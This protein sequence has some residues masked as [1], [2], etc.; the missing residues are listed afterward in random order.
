MRWTAVDSDKSRH[1]DVI[2]TYFHL[3]FIL[4]NII[5]QN[6]PQIHPKCIANNVFGSITL[7]YGQNLYIDRY[8][9][10]NKTKQAVLSN[11]VTLKINTQY[12]MPRAFTS[13]GDVVF[14]DQ[15]R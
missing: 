5:G 7:L 9:W 14:G 10:S 11:G 12:S 1:L 2:L 4:K 15:K 8:R 3:L 6:K 13:E